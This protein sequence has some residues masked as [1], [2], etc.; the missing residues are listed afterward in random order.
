MDFDL[1]SFLKCGAAVL[2]DPETVLVGSGPRIWLSEPTSPSFYF[3]DFFLSGNKPWFV[4]AFMKEIPLNQLDDYL[5]KHQKNNLSST[6]TQCNWQLTSRVHFNDIMDEL[7][8]FL[9]SGDLLKAVPYIREFSSGGIDE[10][11]LVKSLKQ[12]IS[13]CKQYSMHLYGFWGDG[14][15]FLGATPQILFK[16]TGEKNLKTM[17]C[18]GTRQKGNDDYL[19]AS[20]IKELHEHQLVVQ[21]IT[22]SLSPFGRVVLGKQ[23]VKPF[24]QLV[25][26]VTPIHLEMEESVGYEEIV[27]AMH[28]TPAL[29]A[30][31]REFGDKW[32][33]K[34]ACEVEPR[35]RY[36]APAGYVKNDE[37]LALVAIRGM[38][39]QRDRVNL[40]AGSGVVPGSSAEREWNEIQL[41]LKSIKELL[42]L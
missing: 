38:Q 35:G 32:L 2:V 17:A 41:K 40:Y 3:P 12:L 31:P 16:M 14:E 5:Q 7:L 21:S 9:A 34:Y 19:I 15:G 24:N 23:E 4:H 8:G 33:R 13:S 6:V 11:S 18:A 27:Q 28:P 30:I 22:E 25:H 36:G 39:W 37:G 26:L 1:D 10:Q 20:D 29:G 42:S